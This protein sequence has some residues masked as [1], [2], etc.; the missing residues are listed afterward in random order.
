[1]RIILLGLVA[2]IG[3]AGA[4][5]SRGVDQGCIEDAMAGAAACSAADQCP[6]PPPDADYIRACVD[7]QCGTAKRS[8]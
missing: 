5:E 4:V 3:C 1:M 2:S 8:P 7:G 6:C